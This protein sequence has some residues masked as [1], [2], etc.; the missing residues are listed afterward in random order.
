MSLLA[1]YAPRLAATLAAL[2]KH[3]PET[4]PTRPQGG[5]FLSLTLPEGVNTGD[6]R[7]AAALVGLSLADGQGFFSNGGGGSFLR[8]PYCALSP[9]DLED[10]IKRLAGVVH[11]LQA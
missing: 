11:A 7:T 3:L 6:V 10:G 8:L 2:D 5:F 4:A 1:L 9:V